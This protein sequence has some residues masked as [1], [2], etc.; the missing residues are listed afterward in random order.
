MQGDIM[1]ESMK[2]AKTVA[3]NLLES[4]KAKK[5]LSE[6]EKSSFNGLHIHCPDGATPVDGPSAGCAICIALYS[7]LTKKKIDNTIAITGELTLQGN[8]TQIGGLNE[9]I[10]GALNAGVKTILY[11]EDN[12]DDLDIIINKN[13]TLL[14]K[15]KFININNINNAIKYIFN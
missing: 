1:Q 7:L 6:L 13:K 5:I 4:S 14:N 8:I 2:V 12:Q 10:Y 15:I 9:K 11:P 3:L